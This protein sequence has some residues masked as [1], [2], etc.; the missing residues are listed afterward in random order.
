MV[1]QVRE[2]LDALFG[3]FTEEAKP[4]AV[5]P[6][7]RVEVGDQTDANAVLQAAVDRLEGDPLFP[8]HLIRALRAADACW[9]VDESGGGSSEVLGTWDD[10]I[11]PSDPCPECGGLRFWWNARGEPRCLRC[12]PPL[13][14]LR[15]QERALEI[16]REYGPPDS[17]GAVRRLADLKSMSGT[18]QKTI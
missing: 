16:R 4:T 17:P 2:F 3:S 8:P 1:F 10:G 7:E 6:I 11:E 15:W 14:A 18:C 12:E 13:E 9:G 5:A